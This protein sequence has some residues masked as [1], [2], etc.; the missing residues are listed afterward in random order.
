MEAWAFVIEGFRPLG[1]ES[2]MSLNGCPVATVQ[3][4]VEQAWEMLAEPNNY[5]LWWD[6]VLMEGELI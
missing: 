3:V 2:L 1:G 4:P 5:A 6:A